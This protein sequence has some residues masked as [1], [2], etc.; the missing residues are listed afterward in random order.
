MGHPVDCGSFTVTQLSAGSLIADV[1]IV[2]SENVPAIDAKAMLRNAVA[3]YTPTSTDLLAESPFNTLDTFYWNGQKNSVS[4]T[5]CPSNIEKTLEPGTEKE[6]VTWRSPTAHHVNSE[7]STGSATVTAVD[8]QYISGEEF[9]EGAYFMQ[10]SAE[11][12]GIYAVPCTFVIRVTKSEISVDEIGFFN[13]EVMLY[14][15]I[16]AGVIGL[17]GFIC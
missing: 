15:G 17:I 10:F 7:G 13:S 4:F 8:T 16:G 6:A 3:T 1:I 9:G 5:Y 11:H 2:S 14:G 12:N